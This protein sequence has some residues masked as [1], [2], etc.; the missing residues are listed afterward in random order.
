M[1][2]STLR[3]ESSR[4]ATAGR[5]GPIL[6]SAFSSAMWPVASVEKCLVPL[7][8]SRPRR[9]GVPL[10]E[11][12]V[13][14]W[15]KPSPVLVRQVGMGAGRVLVGRWGLPP[16]GVRSRLRFGA[17]AGG[18]G[19]PRGTRVGRRRSTVANKVSLRSVCRVRANDRRCQ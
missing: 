12:E 4:G 10:A 9:E 13:I 14:E 7:W 8:A 1:L 18:C 11:V 5:V 17:G 16:S 3:S 15:H 2:A 19:G 6:G